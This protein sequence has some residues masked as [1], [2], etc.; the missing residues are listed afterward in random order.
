MAS[1][2]H[3]GERI[4]LSSAPAHAAA[5][6]RLEKLLENEWDPEE[7]TRTARE[8][9]EAARLFAAYGASVLPV[10]GETLEVPP[11]E[12]ESDVEIFPVRLAPRIREDTTNQ[13]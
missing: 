11:P 2:K 9:T 8:E 3:P 5:R 13:E 1:R 4:D 6:K 10:L 7:V 12:I